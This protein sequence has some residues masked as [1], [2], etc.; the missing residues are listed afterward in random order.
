MEEE[1]Q[2]RLSRR[3]LA[4]VLAVAT[5]AIAGLALRTGTASAFPV[6]YPLVSTGAPSGNGSVSFDTLT[7]GVLTI[8]LTGATPGHTFNVSVC[9]ASAVCVSNGTASQFTT[10]GTG[11]FNG[12]VYEPVAAMQSITVVD[13][14]NAT[15]SYQAIVTANIGGVPTVVAPGFVPLFS[16]GII[17]SPIVII[18]GGF[19]T[20][21]NG[22]LLYS[23]SQSTYVS[24]LAGLGSWYSQWLLALCHNSLP[25]TPIV[26]FGVWGLEEAQFDCPQAPLR[27]T[28]R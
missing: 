12:I 27:A 26:V 9:S 28:T 4:G 8:S 17:G 1:F 15:N 24:N 16:T 6:L 20:S 19:V 13:V 2:M 10:D 7:P 25:G 11:S 21:P 23:P 3:H 5:L 18:P 22:T 14:A